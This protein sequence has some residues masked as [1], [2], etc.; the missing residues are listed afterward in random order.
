[1][2]W[3]V[4]WLQCNV[5][6][7]RLTSAEARQ[8]AQDKV[9]RETREALLTRQATAAAVVALAAKSAAEKDRLLQAQLTRTEDHEAVRQASTA[10]KLADVDM[11][12]VTAG[13]TIAWS[14][15]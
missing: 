15:K 11:H 9:V 2:L 6:K 12:L 1:M 7:A 3:C 5:L 14:C 4:R 10:R 13:S 8:R